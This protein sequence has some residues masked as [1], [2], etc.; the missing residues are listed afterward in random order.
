ML[1]KIKASF[2]NTDKAAFLSNNILTESTNK[3]CL[4]M[5]SAQNNITIKNVCETVT[6]F[7]CTIKRE[8]S[9]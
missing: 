7:S 9:I 8:T 3:N 4:E 5:N 6:L 2:G 1:N